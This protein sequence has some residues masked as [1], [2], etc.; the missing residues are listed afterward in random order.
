MSADKVT[1]E[2]A[3]SRIKEASPSVGFSST[4]LTLCVHPN[5]SKSIQLAAAI[6]LMNFMKKNFGKDPNS[7]E[8]FEKQNNP[9]LISEQDKKFIKNNILESMTRSSAPVRK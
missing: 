7:L 8:E 5:H 4:L 2:S 1:R 3:E 6:H 9:I